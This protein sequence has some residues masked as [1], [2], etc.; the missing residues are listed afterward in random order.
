ME[1]WQKSN[2]KDQKHRKEQESVDRDKY[3]PSALQRSQSSMMKN[4]MGGNN[5]L[6]N[7]GGNFKMPKMPKL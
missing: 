3:S 6:G 1:A 4:Y 7:M 2:E 5:N